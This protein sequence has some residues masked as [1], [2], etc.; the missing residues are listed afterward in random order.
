MREINI[1]QTYKVSN[2]FRHRHCFENDF[3]VNNHKSD[4]KEATKSSEL[5]ETEIQKQLGMANM[6]RTNLFKSPNNIFTL[7]IQHPG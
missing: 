6:F 7:T 2:T 5:T 3:L 1:D 4:N